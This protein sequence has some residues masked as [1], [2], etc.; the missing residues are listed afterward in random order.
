MGG[1]FSRLA[2]HIWLFYVVSLCTPTQP[3]EYAEVCY[4]LGNWYN[5]AHLV[6]EKASGGHAVLERLRYDYQYRNLAKY[7][8]YD[9]FNKVQWKWG[10]DT[11]AK[12]KSIAVN[13]AVEWFDKGLI[14]LKTKETLNEMKVFVMSDSGKMGAV[15][16]A[17]DDM[18]SALWL[19]IQGLKSPYWYL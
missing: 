9:E 18:V 19:A 3:Y 15:T 11:N 17:H 8:T 16:G 13:D 5:K 6:V 10:F 14:H 12:T 7:K 1:K 2:V 4:L